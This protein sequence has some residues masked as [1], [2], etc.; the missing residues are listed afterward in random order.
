VVDAVEGVEEG[1]CGEVERVERGGEGAEVGG[2]ECETGGQ[3]VEG[4]CGCDLGDEGEGGG[5]SWAGA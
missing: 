1:E 3:G 2:G 4:E 5:G